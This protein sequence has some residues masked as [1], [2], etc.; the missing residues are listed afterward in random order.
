[1]LLWSTLFFKRKV[2]ERSGKPFQKPPQ[3]APS[4][5]F[6]TDVP[7]TMVPYR[8]TLVVYKHQ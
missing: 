6:L 3:L 1:M 7:T 2:S 4:S 8:T 5:H